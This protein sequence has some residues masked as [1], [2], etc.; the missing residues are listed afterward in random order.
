M[1]KC[2]IWCSFAGSLWSFGGGLWS[3]LVVACFSNLAITIRK[4]KIVAENKCEGKH[5]VKNGQIRTRKNSVFEHFSGTE[6]NR[7]SDP[8]ARI[9]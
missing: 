7:V 6:E 2:A 3:F 1:C 4:G 8:E 9:K 5:R